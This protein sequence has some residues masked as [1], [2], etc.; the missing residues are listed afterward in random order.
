MKKRKDSC[1]HAKGKSAA[2]REFNNLAQERS[3]SPSRKRGRGAGFLLF[4]G[5]GEKE[6]LIFCSGGGTEA[7]NDIRK[8]IRKIH[9]IRGYGRRV[10]VWGEN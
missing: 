10:F 3:H 7:S 9:D 4:L 2:S 8:V 5:G 6:E 1:D